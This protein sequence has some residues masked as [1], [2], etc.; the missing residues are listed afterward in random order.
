MVLDFREL[1]EKVLADATS[2]PFL[3]QGDSHRLIGDGKIRQDQVLMSG[4]P[5]GAIFMPPTWRQMAWAVIRDV[6]SGAFLTKTTGYEYVINS[7]IGEVFN[8]GRFLLL[9]EQITY[10]SSSLGTITTTV[11]IDS[12]RTHRC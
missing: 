2:T 10:K 9:D 12:S 4:T 5:Q 6:L 1:T 7:F 11:V 8:S 3:Y